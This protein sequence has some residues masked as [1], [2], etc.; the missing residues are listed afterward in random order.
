MVDISGLLRNDKG[1]R[2]KVR[3]HLNRWLLRR[4]WLPRLG[5]MWLTIHDAFGAPGDTLLTAIVCRH[6]A[7]RFPGIRIN[8]ITPNPELVKE[9]PHI[10]QLNGPETYI[11]LR[12]WYLELIEH[13]QGKVNVLE[14]SMRGIGI[15][16]YDY[17]ASVYLT[18]AERAAGLALL[19]GLSRPIISVNTRSKEPVKNW[20][21]QHW[22]RLVA[23][24]RTDYEVVQLGDET[25]LKIE[26]V[27]SFGGRLGFRESMSVLSQ[28][29]AHVGSD[30]FLMHAANGLRVPSVILFGGSRTPAN[31]GYAGNINLYVPMPCGPC[32]IHQS[33]D[34]TCGHGIE[35]MNRITVEEVHAAVLKLLNRNGTT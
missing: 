14:E 22:E 25:E 35:C 4:L 1:W 18:E 30:S 5:G 2:A 24:L 15:P 19:A 27:R 29:K 34:E 33:R 8:C 10:H 17:R 3:W 16:T 32:Y 9:D 21:P 23:L 6:I 20:P 7:E 31:L 12:H 26:G 13:K 11:C 28:A